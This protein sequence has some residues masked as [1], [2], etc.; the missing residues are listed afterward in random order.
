VSPSGLDFNVH[1]TAQE[2]RT[3]FCVSPSGLDFNVHS[4]AQ[5]T[6]A[7]FCVSPSGLEVLSNQLYDHLHFPQSP[8]LE[9][10][11]DFSLLPP[12]L[13]DEQPKLDCNADAFSMI[14]REAELELSI[15]H[16]GGHPLPTITDFGV[17]QIDGPSTLSQLGQSSSTLSP[18][19]EE[20]DRAA[21]LVC[22]S[23]PNRPSF[24]HRHQYK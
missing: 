1:S 13:W 7:G 17:P 20:S 15:S 12:I 6:R 3:G 18:H 10:A 8:G 16:T 23:C 4:T 9:V 14:E 11:F 21:A 2:T 22:Y 24:G 5:E 19:S